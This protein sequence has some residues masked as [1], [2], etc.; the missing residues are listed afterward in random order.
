M[1]TFLH[2]STAIHC[3]VVSNLQICI[4]P[5][6]CIS[7][8]R[9]CLQCDMLGHTLP[10]QSTPCILMWSVTQ[11][12]CVVRVFSVSLIVSALH[13]DNTS[14][15][16]ICHSIA[17]YCTVM[18]IVAEYYR[19]LYSIAEYCRVLYIIAQYCTVLHSIAEYCTVLHSIG[20]YCT[21]LHSSALDSVTVQN[22]AD[23]A[24]VA[25]LQSDNW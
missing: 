10:T 4:A 1:S 3:T 20:Q 11:C 13:W 25:G 7:R 8:P 14:Q 24:S 18:H 23:V 5:K 21:V 16:I 19:L 6:T 15:F 22:W 12:K 17:E 2:N 9:H